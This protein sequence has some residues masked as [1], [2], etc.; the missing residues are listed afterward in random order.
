M[1]Y[2]YHPTALE[3]W[4]SRFYRNL[5]IYTPEDL[6]EE[7]IAYALD[8]YLSRKDI[9]SFSYEEGKFK[10]ITID[11]RT[12]PE[13]QR[14][15]F[16]HELCHILRHAG[17]QSM[18]PEAFRELQEWDARHFVRYAA[19][20]FH[21]LRYIDFNEPDF[22]LLMAKKFGVTPILCKERIQK[23]KNNSVPQS[24]ADFSLSQFKKKDIFLQQK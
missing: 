9:S 2:T 20:P 24:I 13:E 10:S 21:M 5:N 8:I 18:M 6:D 22:L 1:K 14:E 12:S 23:I 15:Q 7:T 19:I 11:R 4:V 3:S 16:Y 17:R